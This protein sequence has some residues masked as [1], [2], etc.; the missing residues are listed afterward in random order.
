[1][2]GS[3]GNSQIS[4]YLKRLKK[5]PL[6]EIPYRV[7]QSFRKIMDKQKISGGKPRFLSSESTDFDI[8]FLCDDGLDIAS[9]FGPVKSET[10]IKEAEQVLNNHFE[11]FGE[12]VHFESPINF[13]L[14]PKTGNEWPLEFW[15]DID[16]RDGKKIGGIKFAWE[17]N[18]LHHWPKLA[19]AYSITKDQKYLERL[20]S[21]LDNWLESNP[22]SHGINWIMGIEHGIRLANLYYTL[23]TIGSNLLDETRKKTISEFISLH[24]HHLYRFPS[25]YSSCANHA[26]AEALGLFISG[27]FMPNLKSA[28]KWKHFGKSV[29]E[30][31][32][33]NQI[34][35][36]GSSFEHTIPYLQFVT[37]HFLIYY[38]VCQDHKENIGDQVGKRLEAVCKFLSSI[39]DI[40]GN[41]PMIG[42]DD[43]GFLI[44]LW[45]GDHNNYCSLLNTCGILFNK[46]EWIHPAATLD[47]KTVFLLGDSTDSRWKELKNQ[48]AWQ[49]KSFYFDN[50]GLAVMADNKSGKEILFIGNSGPLGLKPLSGHGHADALSFWLSVGGQPY[51]VDPGTYLYH[52]GGRW[53]SYFRSTAAH[54][55]LL[56]DSQDQA[57]QIADLMFEEFYNI[58]DVRWSEDNERV[59]WGAEHDGYGRLTDP[60]IHRREVTY[61]KQNHSFEIADGIECQG[62]HEIKLFFHFHPGIEIQRE[63]D[64]SYRLTDGT[65]ALVLRVDSQLQSRIFSGS[66][67]PIMGWYS[68]GFNRIEKANTL[69]FTKE[70]KGKSQIKSEITII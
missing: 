6:K 46:P 70:I 34:Y 65:T 49:K 58:H 5:M 63:A 53:R 68:P 50:A 62:Q 25:K 1:M 11:I 30:R 8:Q 52:S 57:E 19:I 54:N 15:G 27:L 17:L 12:S 20:F 3:G 44:K 26:V 4:W 29:L 55:T 2:P 22:Y 39:M 36:D 51:F 67:E 60:V 32:V 21:E 9:I 43:D 59:F 24:A 16:F 35:P 10:A 31:E 48:Q 66:E 18:R 56:V 47:T 40:K 14:D 42:D 23:K 45:F 41:I 38:L 33:I 61:K 7:N 28:K 64:N 37:D 69:V 13:H